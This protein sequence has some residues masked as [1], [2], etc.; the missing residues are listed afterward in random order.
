MEWSYVFQTADG[1]CDLINWEGQREAYDDVRYA[2]L[3][4]RLCRENPDSPVSK[5]AQAWLDSIDVTHYSYDPVETRSK[6]V[7][8]ILRLLPASPAKAAPHASATSRRGTSTC[9]PMRA[10]VRRRPQSD[11]TQSYF[12]SR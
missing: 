9:T 4:L 6:M 8:F 10:Y 5:E 1:V 2:T 7:E 11:H 3:L 12:S